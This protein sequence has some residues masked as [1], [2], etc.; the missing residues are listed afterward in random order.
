MGK[1]DP[2][3]EAC[4]ARTRRSGGKPTAH[5]NPDGLLRKP[6][7]ADLKRALRGTHQINHEFRSRFDRRRVLAERTGTGF[8]NA[9][10]AGGPGRNRS[11]SVFARKR[12]GFGFDGS[13]ETTSDRW[14]R[15]ES[16]SGTRTG[17]REVPA[18]RIGQFDA[19]AGT[20]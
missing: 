8:P 17:A 13:E 11:G 9:K 20:L 6:D 3:P 18:G 12:N 7:R 4:V 2:E 19:A 15:Y 5:R 14:N 16:E 1:E 10:A